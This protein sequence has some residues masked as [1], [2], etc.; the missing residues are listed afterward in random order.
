MAHWVWVWLSLNRGCWLNA[1]WPQARAGPE[2][3][4]AANPPEGSWQESTDCHRTVSWGN[5]V[6]HAQT[7][8]FACVWGLECNA[9]V[10]PLVSAFFLRFTD[11]HSSLHSG[12]QGQ[13]GSH[14]APVV[15]FSLSPGTC[16]SNCSGEAWVW[17]QILGPWVVISPKDACDTQVTNREALYQHCWCAWCSMSFSHPTF[18]KV[19]CSIFAY[20]LCTAL[21]Q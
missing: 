9:R 8:E 2:G 7:H 16:G 3:E 18:I 11:V 20:F 6:D 13:P 21:L 19:L 17:M 10:K 1:S 15:P 5:S 4:Q 14:L 12:C